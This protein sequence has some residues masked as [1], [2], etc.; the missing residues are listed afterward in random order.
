MDHE[1]REGDQHQHGRKL[2]GRV[3]TMTVA[4]QSFEVPESPKGPQ[5]EEIKDRPLG[6]QFSSATDNFE[7]ATHKGPLFVRNSDCQD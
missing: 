6:L 5:I 1:G 2:H 3:I 4:S 7:R